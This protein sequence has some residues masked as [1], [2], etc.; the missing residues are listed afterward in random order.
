MNL[1][2]FSV[3]LVLLFGLLVASWTVDAAAIQNSANL[4]IEQTNRESAETIVETA[5]ETTAEG[6]AVETTVET[7]AETTVE[8]TEEMTEETTRATTTEEEKTEETIERSSQNT[9]NDPTPSAESKE[10][11][12]QF[13]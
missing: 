3:K 7:M 12:V 11:P 13:K 8:T 5:P 4:S 2:L 9:E 1:L 10:Q 6:K